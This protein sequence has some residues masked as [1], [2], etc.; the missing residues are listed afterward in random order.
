MTIE[1]I[2]WTCPICKRRYAIPATAPTPSRCPQCRQAEEEAAS[3]A[4]S[5]P[6]LA[7][8]E[9]DE[10]EKFENGSPFGFGCDST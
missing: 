8:A 7:Q 4:R 1:R 9:S 6:L 2:Q 3:S 10:D 5:V